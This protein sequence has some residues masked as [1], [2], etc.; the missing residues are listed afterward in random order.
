MLATFTADFMGYRKG[1]TVELS[2]DKATEAMRMGVAE[3]ALD[4]DTVDQ[5]RKNR[6]NRAMYDAIRKAEA[7]RQWDRAD[8][9][10]RVQLPVLAGKT[11]AD[12]C[13]AVARNQE[14]VL[15]QDFGSYKDGPQQVEIKAALVTTS[16]ILGGYTIPTEWASALMDAVAE[17]AIIRPKALELPM[18]GSVLQVP[19]PDLTTAPA[20]AGI[21]PFFG[22]MQLTWNSEAASL[23][24]TEPAWKEVEFQPRFLSGYGVISRPLWDDGAA[25]QAWLWNFLIDAVGWYEDYAFFQGNGVGQPLGIVNAGARLNV[26]R[27]TANHIRF[28]DVAGMLAK[29]MPGSLTNTCWAFSPTCMTDL[30]QLTDGSNRAVLL[31]VGGDNNPDKPARFQIAGLPAYCTEK[32]PA[33]GTVGDLVLFDPRF[34]AVATR[35]PQPLLLGFSEHVKFLQNQVVFRVFH[36]ADGRPW[37][38]APVTLQDTLTQASPFVVLN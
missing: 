19:F 7:N 4:P 33:L 8:R 31:Q 15:R 14:D 35:Q 6:H 16:G 10:Q 3:I 1:Q 12:F 34:Y 38:N 32:L 17:K 36:R 20:S 27:N 28:V 29:L 37:I 9:Q 23:P 25:L 22:G 21:S 2:I 30:S 18:A 5:F 13:Y 11:F 24:E 26:T